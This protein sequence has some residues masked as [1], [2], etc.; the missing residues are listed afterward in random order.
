[1]ARIA[2]LMGVNI[3]ID[4]LLQLPITEIMKLHRPDSSNW[5][6]LLLEIP[7]R[8]V[9]N[10]FDLL[11]ARA[12]KLLQEG[13]SIAIDN[14]RF[15]ASRVDMLHQIPFAEIKLDRSLVDSCSTHD[16][17]AKTCKTFIQM[18]HN[19]SMRAS[20]VGLSTQEDCRL[21]AELGCD[22]GQGF[23][24]SKPITRQELQTLVARFKTSS[25]KVEPTQSP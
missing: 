4:T 18:A 16:G 11:K 23:A 25:H 10:R 15:G 13:V 19:F 3:G 22:V 24:L 6:G 14:F 12:P 7:E 9:L 21:I 20:A 8:Q 5:P 1:M 2:L 17:H